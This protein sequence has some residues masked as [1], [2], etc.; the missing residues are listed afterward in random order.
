MKNS[1]IAK[2]QLTFQGL[3]NH[4]GFFLLV[5]SSESIAISFDKKNLVSL[6]SMLATITGILVILLNAAVLMR[7]EP[8]TRIIL[9]GI[10]MAN[11]YAIVG[12]G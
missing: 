1:V 9:N 11:G 5:S 12:I 8:R 3:M 2:I 4:F 7:F 10:I 6:L